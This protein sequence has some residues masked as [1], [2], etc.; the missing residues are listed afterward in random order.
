MH[1]LTICVSLLFIYYPPFTPCVRLFEIMQVCDQVLAQVL[2]EY[3]DNSA[4]IPRFLHLT[5]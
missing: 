4:R 2:P 3:S 1:M 5:L